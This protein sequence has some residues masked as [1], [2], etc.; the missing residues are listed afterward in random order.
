MKVVHYQH[1]D[2]GQKEKKQV[3][4]GRKLKA[5]REKMGLT[6]AEAASKAGIDPN[7]FARVERGEEN[8]TFKVLHPIFKVLKIKSLI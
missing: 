2:T 3:E 6:Q 1:M 5:A 4:L 7:Y 8:P